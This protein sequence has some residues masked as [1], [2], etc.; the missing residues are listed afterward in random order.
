V[1]KSR[2][3]FQPLLSDRVEGALPPRHYADVNA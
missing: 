2:P 1:L 3:S